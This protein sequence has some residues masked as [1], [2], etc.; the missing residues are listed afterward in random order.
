MTYAFYCTCSFELLVDGQ[1]DRPKH[2]KRFTRINNLRKGCILLFVLY[3]YIKMH[4]PINVK[5][6]LF[7]ELTKYVLIRSYQSNYA[8]TIHDRL[9]PCWSC[10]YTALSPWPSIR[11]ASGL[12]G[13]G[14]RNLSPK[15]G[16]DAAKIRGEMP[17]LN[18]P[19]QFEKFVHVHFRVLKIICSIVLS[20]K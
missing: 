20:S 17:Q 11:S 3:E 18:K 19:N 16:R 6:G 1:K 9:S 8:V 5:L 2:V 4:G 7:L 12:G 13:R 14:T 15:I 10:L